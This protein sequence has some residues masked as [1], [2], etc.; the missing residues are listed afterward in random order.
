METKHA[1]IIGEIL[2]KHSFTA[3]SPLDRY[4]LLNFILE[5][6]ART[7]TAKKEVE[8]AA[9]AALDLLKLSYAESEEAKEKGIKL[10]NLSGLYVSR[11]TANVE[12]M[13]FAMVGPD[14]ISDLVIVL[15]I[16]KT[17]TPFITSDSPVVRYNFLKV[18]DLRMSDWHSPGLI[19]FLPLSEEITLCL[20]D[21]DVYK[22]K[23]VTNGNIVLLKVHDVNELNRLQILNADEFLILSKPDYQENVLSLHKSLENYRAEGIFVNT[24]KWSEWVNGN[25]LHERHKLSRPKIKYNPHFSFLRTNKS[26]VEDFKKK[27]TELELEHDSPCV[28]VRNEELLDFVE[29]QYRKEIEKA[30]DLSN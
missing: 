6:S 10:E 12:G 3:T 18:K 15:L 19:I 17:N 5:M 27:V 9:N 4:F 11:K 24:E 28:F 25:E 30:R 7:K 2:K 16:N 20:F 22:P 8:A 1:A 21:P 13:L 14:L 26:F 23:A 29:T